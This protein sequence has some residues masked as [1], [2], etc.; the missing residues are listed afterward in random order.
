MNCATIAKGIIA[1]SQ[2]LGLKIP[3]VVRLEG[4]IS[5]FS[6]FFVSLK[7]L[8]LLLLLSFNKFSKFMIY[9]CS[10]NIIYR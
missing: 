7:Y 2:N 3:L 4:K 5:Q 9:L 1:A 6:F 10:Y 8:N